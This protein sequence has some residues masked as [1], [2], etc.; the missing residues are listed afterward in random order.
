MTTDVYYAFFTPELATFGALG[1]IFMQ[2]RFGPLQV[3]A[4]PVDLRG[5]T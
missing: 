5:N 1:F 4:G 2:A 3:A